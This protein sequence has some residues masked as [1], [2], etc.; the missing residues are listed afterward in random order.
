MRV[1]LYAVHVRRENVS[2]LRCPKNLVNFTKLDLHV[3]SKKKCTC[4]HVLFSNPV[5]RGNGVVKGGK[6]VL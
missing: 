5:Y 1:K 4:M 6:T 3:V 2:R